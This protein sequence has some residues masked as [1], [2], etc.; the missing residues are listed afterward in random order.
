MRAFQ[1]LAHRFAT[2][3]KAFHN[4]YKVM[5]VTDHSTAFLKYLEKHQLIIGAEL[6]IKMIEE[7]DDSIIL[8]CKKKEVNIS[9]K[10]AERII[11]EVL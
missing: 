10:V 9:N 2:Q 11:I 6:S 7:F 5:G 8:I 4:H 3:N 1:N